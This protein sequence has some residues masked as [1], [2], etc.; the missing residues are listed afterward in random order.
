M[1]EKFTITKTT[2][3]LPFLIE[4]LDT[5]S[6]SKVKQRLQGKC[7]L[8]NDRVISQHDEALVPGDVVE[9]VAPGQRQPKEIERLEILYLDRELIAINKPAGLLSVST[10]F[11]KKNHALAV[12]RNQ[13]SNPK[14]NAQLWPVN[15]LDRETSGV[16]LFA[17]S[18]ETREAVMENWDQ[19]EKIY[20]AIV[21]GTP[22]DEEGS[23]T[24]P[25]RYDEEQA[26][27]HVGEHPDAK[28]AITHYKVIRSVGAR[29]MLEVNIETGR[30]HQIRAHL[31]WLGYPVMGDEKYG[32]KGRRMALHALRLKL[33]H[34]VSGKE[35]RFETPARPDFLKL[36][37]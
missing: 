9:V 10:E 35:L 27:V 11:D 13:L 5:W 24:E 31:A 4:K 29:S 21:K 28:P 12:L 6:R 25:L 8:V 20:L 7:V 3:L 33:K 16:M 26:S 36:L 18:K 2:T 37:G 17:T 22:E 32:M 34:P 14:Q 15:R 19:T 30:Q 1:S 23:I